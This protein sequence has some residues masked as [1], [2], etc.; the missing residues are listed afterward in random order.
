[1]STA[2]LSS[3]VIVLLLVSVFCLL[4]GCASTTDR[5]AP[6]T[7]PA[8][9]VPDARLMETPAPFAELEEVDLTDIDALAPV[10]KNN[11]SCAITRARYIELQRWIRGRAQ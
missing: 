1:M 7:C 2:K 3:T 9:P 8:P 11:Q 5:A 6:P 10:T 4:N